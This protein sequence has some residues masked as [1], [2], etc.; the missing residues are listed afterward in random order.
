MLGH[1]AI[2]AELRLALTSRKNFLSLLTRLTIEKPSDC[3][4]PTSL[5]VPVPSPLDANDADDA[6]LPATVTHSGR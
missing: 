4:L 6:I 2:T 5:P 3:C 1:V